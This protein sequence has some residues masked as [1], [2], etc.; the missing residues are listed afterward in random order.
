MSSQVT[1]TPQN[2]ELMQ[3]I[4]DLYA[5]DPQF[6]AA[7]PDDAVSA[8]VDDPGMRLPEMVRTVME[9]Y[10]DRPALGQRAVEYVTDDAGHTTAQLLPHYETTTYGQAWQQIQALD[11][12]LLTGAENEVPGGG[13]PIVSPGDRVAMLGFTSVE[14]TIIDTALARAG[15]VAVPLQTSAPAEQ[16][17]PILDETEPVALFADVNFLDDAVELALGRVTSGAAPKRVVV[18]EYRAQVD[19]EREAVER[20]AARLAVHGIAVQTY[21]E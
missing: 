2:E 5:T 14:Y 7:R 10:A 3:R 13:Q 17:R 6:A 12:A 21:S 1:E 9:A 4:A 8:A 11:N 19:D 20:A 16:L 15:V 18:F